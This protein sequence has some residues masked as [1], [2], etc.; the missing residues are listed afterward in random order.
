MPDN[1]KIRVPQDP[2]KI[3]IQ[4]TWEIEYW[5]KTLGCTE[6]ELRAAVAAVGPMVADVRDYLGRNQEQQQSRGR[7]R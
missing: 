4:Q 2:L 3:N 6:T 1:L 5:T 7:G